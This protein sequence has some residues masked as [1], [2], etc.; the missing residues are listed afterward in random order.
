MK[1]KFIYKI[2][3]IEGYLIRELEDREKLFKIVCLREFK[4]VYDVIFLEGKDFFIVKE[5][6]SFKLLYVMVKVRRWL[7]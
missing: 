3:I 1:I 5:F 2:D 7:L 4:C 6:F